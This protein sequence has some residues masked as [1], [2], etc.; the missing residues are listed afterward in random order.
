MTIDYV[1]VGT[2]D[3]ELVAFR[4]WLQEKQCPVVALSNPYALAGYVSWCGTLKVLHDVL[5]F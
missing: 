2:T 3:H 5:Y 4:T 1:A